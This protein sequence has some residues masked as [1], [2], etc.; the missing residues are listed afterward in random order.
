M[1]IGQAFFVG[2]F[3]GRVF[4]GG[5]AD[6]LASM[7]LA[8]VWAVALSFLRNALE[9]SSGSVWRVAPREEGTQLAL[10]D[11]VNQ[12][13]QGASA[14]EEK[15]RDLSRKYVSNLVAQCA[16]A[17][18]E[19]ERDLSRKYVGSLLLRSA[20][21]VEEKERQHVALYTVSRSGDGV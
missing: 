20:L 14:V 21:S 9:H 12:V 5:L 8:A 4:P 1:E 19:K 13:S 17:V 18:Q 3:S 15:E 6:L 16:S 2:T 7:L 11:T 10:C